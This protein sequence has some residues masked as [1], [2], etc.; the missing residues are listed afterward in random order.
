MLRENPDSSSNVVMRRIVPALRGICAFALLGTLSACADKLPTTSQDDQ[1]PGGTRPSTLEVLLSPAD[2]LESDTVFTGFLRPQDAFDS[3]L[4][5]ANQ[6]GA[7]GT[8]L[9]AHALASFAALPDTLTFTAGGTSHTDTAFTFAG[10]AVVAKLDT[11]ASEFRV[12]VTLEVWAL[13]QPFDTA[14][15]TWELAADSAGARRPWTT[16]GGTRA[17]LL[18][19][20]QIAPG[21]TMLGDSV[22]IPLDSLAMA[23]ARV[24][25]KGAPGV[26]VTVSGG[27]ARLQLNSLALRATVRPASAQDTTLALTSNTATRA[28]VFTP[29]PPAPNGLFQVGG[30]VGA[31]SIVRITLPKQLPGCSSASPLPCTQQVPLKNVVLNQVSLIFVPVAVDD[32]FRPTETVHL[33]LRHVL[34]PALGRRAPLGPVVASD[35]VPKG[36]FSTAKDTT[37]M[38]RL[39]DFAQ[40]V[41]QTDS[42]TNTFALLNTIEGHEFGLARFLRQ[43]RLRIVYTLVPEPKLP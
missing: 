9:E 16:P 35:T 43:A 21:D 34:E 18:G 10:G 13:A 42:L 14:T 30:P 8:P 20:L 39:T 28:F 22:R 3:Y 25:L 6:F 41:A 15:V 38:L 2:L 26:L 12:P 11:V 5:V 27:P 40:R 23:Q 37:V 4:L 1:F 29:A 32:G 19:S 17:A 33:Q 7:V 36:V 24:G 31:R